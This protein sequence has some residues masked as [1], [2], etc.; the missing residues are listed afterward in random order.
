MNVRWDAAASGDP[1]G[2]KY[3]TDWGGTAPAPAAPLDAEV[4]LFGRLMPSGW[5]NPLHLHLPAVNAL[6]EVF[7]TLAAHLD[8]DALARLVSP[9]GELHRA[10]RVFVDGAPA[11]GLNAPVR[12]AG[13]TA[14]IEIIVLTAIEGG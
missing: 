10:C 7:G 11:D 6:H 4:W 9:D 2:V 3:N 5:R 1:F 8:A 14:R 12:R 13:R